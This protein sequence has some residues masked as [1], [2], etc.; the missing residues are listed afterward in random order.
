[1]AKETSSPFAI[2]LCILKHLAS[3]AFGKLLE[4]SQ[5]IICKIICSFLTGMIII[6]LTF[7]SDL[8]P[9]SLHDLVL[10]AR[11]VM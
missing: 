4:E 7:G 8:P 10:S 1:M 5:G 9:N 11:T 6:R 3:L 2:C